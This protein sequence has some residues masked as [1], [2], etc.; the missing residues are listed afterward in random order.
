M[1]SI[2]VI[3]NDSPFFP[4]AVRT[5]ELITQKTKGIIKLVAVT[6][7]PEK[8]SILK[9]KLSDQYH[10]PVK[11]HV[12]DFFKEIVS[13]IQDG[14][15]DLALIGADRLPSPDGMPSILPTT[16]LAQLCEIPLG[17]IRKCPESWNKALLCARRIDLQS[18]TVING[19]E[20]AEKLGLDHSLLSVI[21]GTILQKE[22]VFPESELK[23]IELQFKIRHGPILTELKKELE[24]EH[25][26]LLII[27]SHRSEP[28]K[29]GETT[30]TLA[31]PDLT[32]QIIR[33]SSTMVVVL[34]QPVKAAILEQEIIK[35]REL[36]RIVQYVA[37]EVIIYAI[38][39]VAYAAI[40]FHFL[41]DPLEN[42]FKNNLKLYAIISLLLIV[43]QGTLL[44]A[45]TSFLLDRL[46]L[47]RFE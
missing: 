38:L 3:V 6:N 1:I 4:E 33:L 9:Q 14:D 28:I 31:Q 13:E 39:V 40:A 26:D 41:V 36:K 18:D 47:E 44:E 21:P 17:I 12:G 24:A 34:G 46:R 5:A 37:F 8:E 29:T 11:I 19:S 25:Y 23:D 42:F 20:L 43:G 32:V 45:I 30:T 35:P 22:Q 15:Y 10:T 27:G 7:D 2:L 16:R